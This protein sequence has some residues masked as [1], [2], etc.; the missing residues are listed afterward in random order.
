VKAAATGLKP[1]GVFVGGA[2]VVWH[3]SEAEAK[4]QATRL[5]SMGFDVVIGLHPAI[6]KASGQHMGIP[7]AQH[8]AGRPSFPGDCRFV[9]AKG[10]GPGIWNR[11]DR[12]CG[13]QRYHHTSNWRYAS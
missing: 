8:H 10:A 7:S 12:I 9:L 5:E 4:A 11:W 6:A 1:F 13:G 3:R 2:G